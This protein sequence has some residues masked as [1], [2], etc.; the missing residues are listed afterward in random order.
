VEPTKVCCI[1]TVGSGLTRE[2]LTRM[3]VTDSV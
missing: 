1:L 2:Y 3:K